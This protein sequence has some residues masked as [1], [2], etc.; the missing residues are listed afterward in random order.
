[1][2]NTDLKTFFE[3]NESYTSFE[4]KREISNLTNGFELN[5]V[6][7]L[8]NSFVEYCFL[9]FNKINYSLPSIER[10]EKKE[11]EIWLNE[12]HF[13]FYDFIQNEIQKEVR[14]E[15]FN[16]ISYDDCSKFNSNMNTFLYEIENIIE[17]Q[18]IKVNG[19]KSITPEAP[20][21]TEAVK[22]KKPKKTLFEFIN[23]INDK[24]AFL[25]DLKNTFPTEIGKSIKAIID[26]L[27]KDKYLI[28]NDREFSDVVNAIE[29]FF[30]RDI[31]SVQSIRDAKNTDDK[32]F[33]E[34]IKLKLNPLIIKY[35]TT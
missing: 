8:S 27:K 28:H 2:E 30:N 33:I 21:Q 15:I 14:I 12:F 9:K 22:P 20:K 3:N 32:I 13:P 24:K 34:P 16:N 10:P 26:L 4:R 6:T 5:L 1:M 18:N 25:Q 31:G 11:G 17:N 29:I 23:N 35:K 7:E 19:I